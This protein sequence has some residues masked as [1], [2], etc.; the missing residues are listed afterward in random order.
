M[1]EKCQCTHDKA[2]HKAT[3]FELFGKTLKKYGAES[4]CEKCDCE[5]F[6]MA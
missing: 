5:T 6:R 1:T 3:V 4:P 2:D